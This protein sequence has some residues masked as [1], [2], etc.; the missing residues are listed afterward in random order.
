MIVETFL[1]KKNEM[2]DLFSL[3]VKLTT[4]S[5]LP[6]SSTGAKSKPRLQQKVP[7]K[8][9]PSP[10]RS[11][12]MTTQQSE[13]AAQPESAAQLEA[14]KKAAPEEDPNEDWCAVCQN[15]GELLCCDKCPKV[16]HLTCHIPTLIASPR[17]EPRCLPATSQLVP[18]SRLNTAPSWTL[19]N[20]STQWRMV[21]LLLPG[22]GFSWNGVQ[23]QRRPG[24]WRLPTHRQTGAFTQLFSHPS[25]G[26]ALS[27]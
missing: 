12:T 6:D 11:N 22:H 15:G 18:P 8:T 7:L 3:E 1:C 5:S 27:S 26:G 21:L 9:P 17:W 10:P 25:P 2:N 16:F 4:G 24:L 14:E 13:S 23:L 20:V 19:T